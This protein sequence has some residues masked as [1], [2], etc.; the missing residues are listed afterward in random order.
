[1]R[2][3]GASSRST[4]RD[5]TPRRSADSH[6]DVPAHRVL[7]P[8]RTRLHIRLRTP[9]GRYWC[10]GWRSARRCGTWRSSMQ[11]CKRRPRCHSWM[12]RCQLS[13]RRRSRCSARSCS[14]VLTEDRRWWTCSSLVPRSCMTQRFSTTTPTSTCWLPPN[15]ASRPGGSSRGEACLVRAAVVHQPRDAGTRRPHHVPSVPHGASSRAGGRL[16][17]AP[18]R[19]RGSSA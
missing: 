18:D 11:R 3:Q 13:A 17:I 15:R 4:D 8:S 12:T 2:F 10:R 7:W 6:M 14:A 9:F 16:V 19:A 5:A 1:M